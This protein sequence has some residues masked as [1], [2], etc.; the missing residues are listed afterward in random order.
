MTASLRVVSALRS[1]PRLARIIRT[2]ARML[3]VLMQAAR[4]SAQPLTTF[5]PALGCLFL[6]GLALA[7]LVHDYFARLDD[8]GALARAF[9]RGE[10]LVLETLD[11]PLPGTL[12][13]ARA[14]LRWPG[15][16]L[17]VF[18]AEGRALVTQ[19]DSLSPALQAAMRPQPASG[20]PRVPTVRY[21]RQLQGTRLMIADAPIARSGGHIVLA[22]PTDSVLAGWRNALP[23][24][25]ALVIVPLLMAL[26]AAQALRDAAGRA[27]LA[28]AAR[29][30]AESQLSFA[31]NRAGC[32]DWRWDLRTD[33]IIWSQSFAALIGERAGEVW[34]PVSAIA[35][36]IHAADRA[37][38]H[39]LASNALGAESPAEIATTLR[40]LHAEGRYV[41]LRL[42][43]TI[44]HEDGRALALTG[45]AIDI[46]AMKR[47]EE[48]LRESEAK[49]A[50][51]V[52]ELEE[53]RGKLREQTRYLMLLA[54]RYAAEKR[55]AEEASR[56]KSEFLANMSHE[57]RT[58]LNAILG[59]SDIMKSEM[60]GAIGDARY[61][62]YAQDIHQAGTELIALIS[63][64]LDM[65][66][67]DSGE[68]GLEPEPVELKDVVAD[69]LRL[70]APRSMEANIKT[71]V[72]LDGLPATLADRRA[73]KQILLNLL[74]NAVKFTPEGGTIRITGGAEQKLVSLSVADTGIGIAEADLP[75]IGQPFVQIENQ[76]N[77][78]YKGS[79][80]GLALA[81]SLVELHGGT[82][83]VTSKLGAGTTVT[84]TFPRWSREGAP[85][86]PLRRKNTDPS[87]RQTE[88]V[89]HG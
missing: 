23:S 24:A 68:R 5:L 11:G 37:A 26:L 13:E 17:G 29:K 65:S 60:F 31:E 74:S 12:S 75:R 2:G 21:M 40:L 39:A 45:V 52:A 78:R 9:V 7:S 10:A 82:L 33:R 67:I 38:F 50:A 48:A 27:R 87:D 20:P 51:S 71:K 62:G 66:H 59:F 53:S 25:I 54:E 4:N 1:R 43:G 3:P 46:T 41:W 19:P 72:V 80:L 61:R 81:K 64:I 58:P 18:D 76:Y 44:E 30:A 56:A 14:V 16:S 69:V 55:R 28:E 36:L 79:G 77:K 84:V 86:I 47:K 49:L 15:A 42:A 83:T 34:R 35:P 63:D 70:V 8:A 88:R 85:A 22:V 32:G 73:L 57:L 89:S 6:A